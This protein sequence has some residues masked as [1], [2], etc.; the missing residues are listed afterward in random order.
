MVNTA[1]ATLVLSP[2]Y[3]STLRWHCLSHKLGGGHKRRKSTTRSAWQERSPV[4]RSRPIYRAVLPR[5]RGSSQMPPW[6]REMS[7]RVCYTG[8][9]GGGWGYSRAGRGSVP[10]S[11]WSDSSRRPRRSLLRRQDED[12]AASADPPVHGPEEQMRRTRD[13]QSGPGPSMEEDSAAISTP[14]N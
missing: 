3:P 12:E 13:P 6:E 11:S 7:G 2:H 14:S 8:D 5:C 1:I 10:F 9:K 4:S